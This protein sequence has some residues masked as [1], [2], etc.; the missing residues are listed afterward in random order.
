MGVHAM[1]NDFYQHERGSS[2]I[3]AFNPAPSAV[4]NTS[5]G[6]DLYLL[7]QGTSTTARTWSEIS[8]GSITSSPSAKF[9]GYLAGKH[10]CTTSLVGWTQGPGYWG[11]TFFVWPPDPDKNKDWRKKFFLN[12]GGSHPTYNGPCND[13]RRLYTSGTGS[14]AGSWQDPGTAAYV[15][16]YKNILKWIKDECVQSSSTDPKPFPAKLRAGR[17]LFYDA[18]PDDVPA[19]AYDHATNNANIAWANQNQRFWKE[20]ID[21]T[22]GVWR[23]PY[24]SIR[25]PNS[26]SCSLGGDYTSGSATSGTDLYIYGTSGDANYFTWY[27]DGYIHPRDNPK[28]PRHRFWFG[29]MTMIQFMS[30]TGLL[31]G[32]ARDISLSVAKLGINGALK[33]IENNHPNDL[34]TMLL[35]NRPQF[36]NDPPATGSF[37]SAQFALSRDYA[38][39]IS[40]LWYPPNSET[41]DVLPWDANG[42]ETPRGH[43]DYNA[44]TATMHG[45]LLAYN[46]MSSNA[47]LKTTMSGGQS[48][49]G[50]GRKGAQRIIV[51]ETDGMANINTNV[52]NGFANYGPN[53]SYY[54]ILPGDT[55]NSTGYSASNLYP[56]VQAICNLPDGM[57]GTSP[58]YSPNPGYPGY[59]TAS[60]PVLIHTLA[61][62][63][64]FEPTASGTEASNAVAFLQQISTIGG[65][66][67]PSSSSDPD[68]GYKWI[69]GTLDERKA[70]LQQAFRN[71][72]D[73]GNSVSLVR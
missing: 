68:N 17:I 45:F 27:P 70:K 52:V 9:E 71:I 18:I 62:G 57:P 60:K 50:L 67:F 16:N 61:F 7:K 51:L 25:K 43:G 47:T 12:G 49:G 3:A 20:Y 6:G 66:V 48:V 42:L 65:T 8:H 44:N 26:P 55:V 24:G 59:A 37:N 5:P 73:T 34:V 64:V 14:S 13:N 46:Q 63:A 69:I 41:S 19:A 23:D 28:R 21:Y 32:T 36:N 2:P 54:H 35:Y 40:A 29:P 39:M 11:K 58:G 33:D 10:G 22:L 1:V 31:P 30:D 56:V 72:M 53:N 38:G 15:I 4:T